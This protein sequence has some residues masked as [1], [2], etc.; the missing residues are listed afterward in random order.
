MAPRPPRRW[1]S[2]SAALA[3]AG[4]GAL[5]L[6]AL[7]HGGRERTELSPA[8]LVIS[9]DAVEAGSVEDAAK[10]IAQAMGLENP[11]VLGASECPGGNCGDPKWDVKDIETAAGP[12]RIGSGVTAGTGLEPASQRAR[13]MTTGV[14]GE[15]GQQ[16]QDGAN[17]AKEV[18]GKVMS[19]FIKPTYGV[20]ISWQQQNTGTGT[21]YKGSTQ[22][23]LPNIVGPGH[24][25]NPVQ[26]NA[27]IVFP[28]P[29]SKNNPIPNPCAKGSG[30]PC[31]NQ[32][33]T[34]EDMQV[35]LNAE[36]KRADERLADER[37]LWEKQV[38]AKK[39]SWRERLQA[40]I[41]RSDALSNKIRHLE[42]GGGERLDLPEYVRVRNRV[43]G[44]S[45]S[46]AKLIADE[47]L[48]ESHIN[49]VLEEPG[50]E[51]KRGPPG[52]QGARGM[53]GATGPP[54]APGLPG[55]DGYNGLHGKDGPPGLA[56]P[57][58][59]PGRP[60]LPGTPGD[61][62]PMGPEGKV[63]EP[64]DPGP[65]GPPGAVGPP[66]IDGKAGMDGQMGPPGPQ[67]LPGKNGRDGLPGD[68]GVPGSEG[69][70]GMPG[71]DGLPGPS[72]RD[73][74]IGRPGPPGPPGPEGKQGEP[75]QRRSPRT[76]AECRSCD[77]SALTVVCGRIQWHPWSAGAGRYSRAK[78][79]HRRA[80][81]KRD[82]WRGGPAERAGARHRAA[83]P[84]DAGSRAARR[85]ST[86]SQ[87]GAGCDLRLHTSA[88]CAYRRRRYCGC[89]EGRLYVRQDVAYRAG[90]AALP[91]REESNG[92][93]EGKGGCAE[94]GAAGARQSCATR[95]R[96]HVVRCCAKRV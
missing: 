66:G 24:S 52:E 89:H 33:Y 40:L 3:V 13:S 1:R 78:G 65:T 58:G 34:E 83:L 48:L 73:G 38:L 68:T 91:V 88:V 11:Q 75:R 70:V 17:L 76:F 64:G 59:P 7:V 41:Q 29:E 55:K 60:G 23:T 80:R 8:P 21:T 71:R 47:N 72:G 25:V 16:A 95:A 42:A 4:V 77:L 57:P 18:A 46:V 22:F 86:G 32:V 62:G 50:P 6:V 27:Q 56:G 49:H 2:A 92:G 45:D 79:A 12:V 37:K 44:M 96:A 54:G 67:G 43:A 81:N 14:A 9:G 69:E 51:G 82:T 30:V 53:P 31:P 10:R 28:K 94:E 15:F 74:K 35:R 5:V 90:Q 93:D 39:Q 20:P 19:S 87:D 61:D 85:T 84:A 26:V 36:R 63:G